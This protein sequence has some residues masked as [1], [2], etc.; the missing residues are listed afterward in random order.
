MNISMCRYVAQ[1]LLTLV[2]IDKFFENSSILVL[3]N[4]P[5]LEQGNY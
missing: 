4:L 5:L 2:G 3:N 1:P